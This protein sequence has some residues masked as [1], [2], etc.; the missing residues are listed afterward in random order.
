MTN[1]GS[2][3]KFVTCMGCPH[4]EVYCHMTCEGY[5]FRRKKQD[6]RNKKIREAKYAER[7][8]DFI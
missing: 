3:D 5:K 1:T 7:I 2:H 8:T 6:E 4:R